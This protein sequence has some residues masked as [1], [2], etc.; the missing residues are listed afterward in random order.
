MFE[1]ETKNLKISEELH[2][3]YVLKEMFLDVINYSDYEHA[4][5]EIKGW[6]E[7]CKNSKIEEFKEVGNTINNWLPYIVNSFI[8]KRLQIIRKT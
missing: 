1:I 6:I 3:G 7:I 2:Q 8:D 5:E 4:E